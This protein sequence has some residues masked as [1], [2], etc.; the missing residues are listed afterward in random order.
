MQ[1]RPKWQSV[2]MQLT[3]LP[4]KGLTFSGLFVWSP[5]RWGLSWGTRRKN[6]QSGSTGVLYYEGLERMQRT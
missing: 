1:V 6:L 3:P 2:I 4:C 5:S